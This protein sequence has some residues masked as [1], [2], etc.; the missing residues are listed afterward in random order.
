[1]AKAKRIKQAAS[2]QTQR[3]RRSTGTS[4]TQES[5]ETVQIPWSP[6]QSQARPMGSITSTQ[7]TNN[8]QSTASTQST[9]NTQLT[10]S[11]QS[12]SATEK[13]KSG[14]KNKSKK[15]K[16]D[17]LIWTPAMEK[18]AIELYVKAVEAGKRGDGGFKPE[19]H[20]HVA[21]ELL[22]EFPGNPFD[23]TK[24]KSKYTQGFK[25][26]YDAFVAC[27]GA[28]GFGWNEADCMVVASDDVWDE[29]LV[30]H[31]CA[32]RFR[33]TPFPEYNDYQIIFEGHTARGDMRQSSG[34]ELHEAR[35]A[36]GKG[37]SREDGTAIDDKPEST[38]T[39]SQRSGVRPPRRHRVTSG[40]RFENSVDRL[41]DALVA[42]ETAESSP[43][44]L[45]MEKFQDKFG[46]NLTMDE[47]VAGFDVLE[48]ESKAR[49]FLAIKS[50][51][52]AWAWMDRQI[53]LK[54]ATH[55]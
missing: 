27:K 35:Q 20:P 21:S 8:T 12:N 29:F 51:A 33:N 25:K 39:P 26:T 55:E 28:S 2:S 46:E 18:S 7:S 17:S 22:K 36:S 49:S 13:P 41:V 54:M 9:N 4:G 44:H 47:R 3:S 19:V 14:K 45:A 34:T 5:Q 11:T 23:S 30:S 16:P 6:T 31:P 42:S 10:T 40:D 50:D 24:V 52:H 37:T 15:D 38:Q 53:R 48:V 43:I 1:M 32:K